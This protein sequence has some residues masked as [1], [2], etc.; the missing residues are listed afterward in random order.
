[1][2]YTYKKSPVA[3]G[4]YEIGELDEPRTHPGEW[5]DRRICEGF[6]GNER[7]AVEA[8]TALNRCRFGRFKHCPE[9]GA[10][11]VQPRTLDGYCEECGWPDEVRN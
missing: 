1:M 7:K 8:V 2:K 5:C 11:V 6:W 3:T 9:C 10:I 4:G